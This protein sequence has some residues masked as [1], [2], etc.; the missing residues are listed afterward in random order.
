MDC[1]NEN[2]G[3]GTP[4][5]PNLPKVTRKHD[6]RA[7]EDSYW[8]VTTKVCPACGET[9]KV[10]ELVCPFCNENFETMAPLTAADVKERYIRRPPPEVPQKKG[11]LIVFICG[12]LGCVAPFNLI[13]GGILVRPE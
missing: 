7:V 1:W 11:A 2:G 12:L 3:C 8:G 4:G 9:I 6:E 5:C 10:S 13:F